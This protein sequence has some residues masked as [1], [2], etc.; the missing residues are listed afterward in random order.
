[1]NLFFENVGG[2][3]AFVDIEQRDVVVGDLVQKNDEL[4]E[5]G[6]G[7]LPEGFLALAKQVVQKRCDAVGQRVGVEIV[8]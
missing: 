1:M 8:M 3:G 2:N 5:V 6:V 4:D 7:L